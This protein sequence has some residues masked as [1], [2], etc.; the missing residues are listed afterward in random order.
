MT[1]YTYIEAIAK[2][3][4]TVQ[5]HAPGLGDVYEDIVW[6]AGAP[7]PSKATLDEWIVANPVEETDSKIT[8]LAFR[9]RF[10]QTEKVTLDLASIDNPSATMQQRQMAAALRVMQQDINA[11]TYIDLSRSDTIAGVNALESYGI[12][13]A[14]RASVI[15]TAPIQDIERPVIHLTT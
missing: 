3:F 13:G 12:I 4:P 5:V 14:G 8:V 1:T 6:D 11:A 15:L 10:T 9:N 2:G 7:L